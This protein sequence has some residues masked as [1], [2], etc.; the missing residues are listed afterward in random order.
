MSETGLGLDP[1]AMTERLQEEVQRTIQRAAKGLSY[2]ASPAPT[3]GR[4]PKDLLAARGP[5]RLY[6]YRPLAPEIYRVPV[7]LVMA[8]TNRGYILDLAPGQSFVE[9]MLKCGFDLYLLDWEAPAP[10]ERGLR[11]DD[12]VADF[13]P[14]A[15]RRVLADSGEPDVSLLGYC[16]GGMLSVMFAGSHPEAPLKN[17]VCF[18]TPVDFRH[19]SLFHRMTDQKSFDV[20]GLVDTLGNIPPELITLSFDLL[21]PATRVAGQ[22]KLWDNMWNDDFVQSYRMFDRWATDS[23]PL[24]GEYF[25][26]T[27]KE[28][29]WNN[30]FLK[31]ELVLAGRKVDPG[32]ITAPFLHVSAEHDHIVPRE[33]SEPLLKMVGSQEKEE[34]VLKGGHV[35]LV[36]GPNAAKRMWPAL[37]AWL[38]RRST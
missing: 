17:L 4:T 27:V 20:D 22:V 13:I 11:M 14:D 18:T 35:S 21:R 3:M 38:S 1:V 12:Y 26:Q 32:R 7:L 16:A 23:L 31:G 37:D 8:T 36:A 5:M 6:H 29:F 19:L 25:R 30:S 34:I 10:H 33:A 9:F 15:M 2:M 24:A 28:L